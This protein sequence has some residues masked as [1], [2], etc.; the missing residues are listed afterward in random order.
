MGML[1]RLEIVPPFQIITCMGCNHSTA[2]HM[3]LRCPRCG[4]TFTAAVLALPDGDE[5]AVELDP[6]SNGAR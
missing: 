4:E 5:K 1:L 2:S 3:P 6:A